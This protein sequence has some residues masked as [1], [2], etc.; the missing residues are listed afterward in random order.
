MGVIDW[1]TDPWRPWLHGGH[2]ET[3]S[4]K[5]LDRE[6]CTNESQSQKGRRELLHVLLW[7]YFESA[8][9]GRC[10]IKRRVTWN[11]KACHTAAAAAAHGTQANR[12]TDRQDKSK[13]VEKK[14]SQLE[15]MLTTTV[16]ATS[17]SLLVANKNSRFVHKE[18]RHLHLSHIIESQ[19]PDKR[20]RV[21][22]LAFRDLAQHQWS[23]CASEHGQ[24]PQ[25]PVATVIVSWALEI[26]AGD[27]SNLKKHSHTH[28]AQKHSISQSPTL[29]RFHC[30]KTCYTNSKMHICLQHRCKSVN[31]PSRIRGRGSTC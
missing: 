15:N 2:Q 4:S 22:L 13:K 11:N 30:N 23:I 10:K 28:A 5:K 29:R 8:K 25:G 27:C 1:R 9:L 12:Q 19:H 17:Y 3:C 6:I 16:V 31:S 24:L 18:S 7:N 14:G 26:G 20:F 21:R